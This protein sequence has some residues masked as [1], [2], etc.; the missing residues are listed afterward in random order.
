MAILNR[1]RWDGGAFGF[2]VRPPAVY[3]LDDRETA[4]RVLWGVIAGRQVTVV[5]GFR[6]EI[7]ANLQSPS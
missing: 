7:P 1:I 4:I 2:A 6:S 5:I 3:P